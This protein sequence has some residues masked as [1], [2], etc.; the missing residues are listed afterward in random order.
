MATPYTLTAADRELCD[1][2][3][4]LLNG[5]VKSGCKNV[6]ITQHQTFV[7]A[8]CQDE[9]RAYFYNDG[10]TLAE[11][12]Q[13]CLNVFGRENLTDEERKAR[14]IAE[15]RADLDRLEGEAA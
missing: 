2:F 14:R 5:I 11:R 8:H 1:Q 12:L 4:G 9:Y 13:S 15:L 10:K 6:S 7:S 3:E